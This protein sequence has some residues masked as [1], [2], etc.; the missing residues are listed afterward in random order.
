MIYRRALVSAQDFGDSVTVASKIGEPLGA[1]ADGDVVECLLLGH[2]GI[3][4]YVTQV[5]KEER[6]ML[7]A[8]R[9]MFDWDERE[10]RGELFIQNGYFP[11][12]LVAEGRGVTAIVVGPVHAGIIEPGRFTFSSGGET[13]VHL[14]A[15]LSYSRRGVE[16]ALRGLGCLEA[17]NRVARICASCSVARSYAYALAVERLSG[18]DCGEET[19]LARLALAELER[20]Y[21]HLFDM[22]VACAGAGYGRGQLEGYRLKERVQRLCAAHYGHR[23]LFD[24]IVPGGVAAGEPSDREILR[25]ALHELKDVVKRYGDHLFRTDSLVRRFEG[26]GIVP[27]ETA[28]AFGAVGPT[29]RASAL[30]FDVRTRAPYGAYRGLDPAVALERTGDVLARVRVKYTEALESIR[31]LDTALA[32]LGNHCVKPRAVS[33][34]ASGRMAVAVEGP[35]GAETVSIECIDGRIAGCHF[36]SASYRNWPVVTRAMEGNIV[37]D[38]PLV[39]KSFNLCYACADR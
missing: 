2:D 17:A 25:D 9:P 16:S 33:Q 18:V 12:A 1:F 32:L 36:I 21:N 19:D 11:E 38:F 20:L 22:A 14:D 26:A 8:A 27:A 35:R 5:P 24:T 6:T 39:N 10:M 23:Y 28:A 37:P 30:D 13:V 3:T 34:S 4:A 15:Q 31:L 29:R 7:A